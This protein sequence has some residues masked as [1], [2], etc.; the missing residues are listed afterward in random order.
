MGSIRFALISA[1]AIA[2]G[3][4][5]L[6]LTG[7]SSIN[8]Q[9][10]D[11]PPRPKPTIV[12]VHGAWADGSS[13]T[14]VTAELQSEGFTVAVVPNPLRGVASDA[15]YLKNYLATVPGPVV[16]VG[17]SYGGMVITNAAA[18]ND[19]VHALVY[20]NAYIPQ[21]GDTIESLTAAQPGSALDPNTAIDAVPLR[22][23]AGNVTDVDLYVKPAM[24]PELFA[25]HAEAG[26]AAV[27]AADQRPL[28]VSALTEAFPGVPAWESAPSWALVGTADR[29]LPP[30]EQHAMAT[31]AQSQ[32]VEVDAPHLS[33]VSDPF[34]VATLI[35]TAA[36]ER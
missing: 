7:A 31:R 22:D 35:T 20:V 2:A 28:A 17:H 21:Q 10:T 26:M 16:L 6:S 11:D 12:L 33:M 9:S 30:A 27:L 8:T 34:A 1:A 29:V 14:A 25:A 23:G 36:G 3:L 15:Q 19:N 5:G 24:F 18:G 32:V 13:W 4:V